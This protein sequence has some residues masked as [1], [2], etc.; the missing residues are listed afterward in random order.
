MC[1]K[2]D[3]TTLAEIAI[4][5]LVQKLITGEIVLIKKTQ[6]TYKVNIRGKKIA[7]A[8]RR[9]TEMNECNEN[10]PNMNL[11]VSRRFVLFGLQL[12]FG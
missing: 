7:P 1:Y 10:Y 6:L 4:T 8:A 5:F 12:R 3:N 11:P 2:I 9:E